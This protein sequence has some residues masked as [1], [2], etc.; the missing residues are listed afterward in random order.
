MAKKFYYI[1]T[2][3]EAVFKVNANLTGSTVRV[4]VR[5]SGSAIPLA[6]LPSDITTPASG[7]IT[8]DISDLTLGAYELQIEQTLAGKLAHYPNKGFDLIIIGANFG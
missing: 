4:L 1:E 3:S 8:V 7:T 5:P 6:E 2:D